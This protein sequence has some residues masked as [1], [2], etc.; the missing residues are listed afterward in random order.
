MQ[1]K[2]TGTTHKAT[3]G[4]A[5]VPSG[6]MTLRAF[7]RGMP[8][9]NPSH[10]QSAFLCLV[11]E[12]GKE[13]GEGPT[14]HTPFGWG[15]PFG[16]HALANIGEVFQHQGSPRGCLGNEAL[17]QDMITITTEARLCASQEIGRA[18]V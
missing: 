10:R 2:A 16:L 6:V 17:T 11:R 5:I 12:E 15:M 13:L 7:L 4:T 8:G 18:H 14:M 3:L 1:F 9:I